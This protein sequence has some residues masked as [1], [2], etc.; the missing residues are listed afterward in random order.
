MIVV[1]DVAFIPMYFRLLMLA[2]VCPESKDC[3]QPAHQT[4]PLLRFSSYTCYSMKFW[5]SLNSRTVLETV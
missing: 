4:L 2:L 5:N 1:I 3:K